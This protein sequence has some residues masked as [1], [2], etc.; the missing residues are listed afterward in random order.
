ME[1]NAHQKLITQTGRHHER[2]YTHF[3]PS[4][5]KLITQTGRHHERVYTHFTPSVCKM[6]VTCYCA[7]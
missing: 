7:T 4:V 6:C 5:C 2:V 1:E 3:T